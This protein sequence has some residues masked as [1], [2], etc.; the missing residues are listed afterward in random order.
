MTKRW[1][2]FWVMIGLWTAVVLAGSRQEAR[3]GWQAGTAKV[4][5]T[6]KQPLWMSGYASRTRPSEGAVHD[7]W[8]K[9]L[10]LQ[11]PAGRRAVL[12]TLD[13][14]GIDR[15]LSGR[16]RDT[17]QSRHKLGRDRIVLACSHT[18]CGPV[19]GTNLLTM[20]KIDD[21]ERR[22]IAEYAQTLEA[23]IVNVAGE[24]LSR[25]Q[26]A[27]ITWGNGRCDFAVNRRNNREARRPQAPAEYGPARSRRSR[28]PGPPRGT[29]RR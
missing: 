28:C 14:C 21:A 2:V 10:A 26:D 4:A 8:A 25:L 12:I 13:V 9:A 18:H 20:Y 24:A 1:P 15:E 22:R 27:R 23:A 19:V 6:P 16:I 17:L 3:A 5:I 11:D 29:Y 7:L